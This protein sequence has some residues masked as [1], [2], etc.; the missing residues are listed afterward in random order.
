MLMSLNKE[1]LRRTDIQMLENKAKSIRATCIKMAHDGKEG[2][3]NGALS[4]VDLLVGL[5]NCW[6][7]VTPEDPKKINRDRFIFSKG[8]ACSSLY[9]VMADRGFFPKQWIS[10]YAQNDSPLPSHPCIHALPILECS[11]GSLGHGLGMATGMSYGL[12][13]DGIQTRVA[14]LISDGECNEGSTWEAATFA[15]ANR[16]DNLLL[17]VDY[18]RIQSVGRSDNLMG[19]TSLEEKYKAFGW[20]AKTINGNN[21]SE[22]IETLNE[23][24]FE[25]GRPSAIIAK[26][27]AG[28]G[29]SFMEDQV[30]WH[31]RVPSDEDLNKALR[32]LNG[33]PVC[34]ESGA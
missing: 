10:R 4:C 7:N 34:M 12:R 3:L 27:V 24:P 2:H 29:A 23:F 31:Y 6:L 32:E 20:A 26:T 15:V 13:M 17:I 18:N 30:L 25:K 19:F 14:V 33:F 8:H 1:I 22:I 9:A 21:I 16:L 5:Y 28:A 11:S